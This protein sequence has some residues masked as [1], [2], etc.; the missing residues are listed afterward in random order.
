MNP[1]VFEP[2]EN[3]EPAPDACVVVQDFI[4]L[5]EDSKV[6]GNVDSFGRIDCGRN[7]SIT[8]NLRA[9]RKV[10]L[11]AACAVEGNIE[12]NDQISVGKNAIIGDPENT[13]TGEVAVLQPLYPPSFYAPYDS[14]IACT[15]TSGTIFA[16]V[17]IVVK[18][19]ETVKV[20]C[21][22]NTI[23]DVTV[24]PTGVAIFEETCAQ[25]TLLVKNG[26]M[27]KLTK[28]IPDTEFDQSQE[29]G[30]VEDAYLFHRIIL[31]PGA[32]FEHAFTM[33]VSCLGVVWQGDQVPMTSDSV[34]R[35]QQI[36]AQE[37]NI[38]DSEFEGQFVAAGSTLVF[39]GQRPFGTHTHKGLFYA[40]IV[41][42][43]SGNELT[44]GQFAP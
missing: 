29:S 4:D 38:I 36:S 10:L 5:A 19:G 34:L 11:R 43:R 23:H 8:G 25:G 28:A 42:L 18:E 20:P 6:T 44:C 22:A 12:A 35:M 39:G 16:T 1:F 26:G 9:E 40:G 3:P 2:E 14:T 31:R 7:A 24:R 13:V 41:V 27:V 30:L 17:K 33:V 32:K 15:L 37:R 21:V